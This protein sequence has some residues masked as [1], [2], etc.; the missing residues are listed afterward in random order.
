MGR[1]NDAMQWLTVPW[2]KWLF[3]RRKTVDC[4]AAGSLFLA[5]V[6]L[7]YLCVYPDMN[8]NIVDA[9]GALFSTYGL[10]WLLLRVELNGAERGDK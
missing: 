9:I 8:S 2:V 4:V 7:V 6:L 10:V 3:D 5:F 1:K